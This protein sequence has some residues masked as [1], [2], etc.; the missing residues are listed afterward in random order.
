MRKTLAGCENITLPIMPATAQALHQQ[1]ASDHSNNQVLQRILMR[2]PAA[3]IA[4]YRRIEKSRPGASDIITGPA[5]ALSMLGFQAFTD[6]LNDLPQSTGPTENNL[7]QAGFAYSQA[8][9]AG[10]FARQLGAAI[11]LGNLEEIAVAALLQN[12]AI[13]ALW[14]VDSES[15]ARA[16]NAVRDGV[17]FE[18]AFSAELGEPLAQA[19]RRLAQ[20]WHFPSLA[21]EVMGNWDPL[22]KRPQ[23]VAFAN[24]LA[25]TTFAAWNQ[26]SLDL[27]TEMLHEFLGMPHDIVQARWRQSAA[28]AARE[29]NIPGYPLPAF[30]LVRLPGGE[31]E[32]EIPPL[33][34]RQA[35][36][37]K[38]QPKGLQQ[39]IAELMRQAQK[40]TGSKRAVFG[41]LNTD[42]SE[43][44]A[45]LALGG[46]KQDPMRCFKVGMTGRNLFSVLMQK[47]QSVWL[48][49]GNR[50]K[51]TPLLKPLPLDAAS[52]GGFFAMSVFAQDKPLGLLYV[53]GGR[54]DAEGYKRFRRL[55][56][57]FGHTLASHTQAAA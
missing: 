32:V 12:P 38:A 6:L 3:T 39:L 22:K 44:Q 15:A 2:D 25:Q 10:W 26:E 18:N 43:L 11:A 13:L 54:L 9:H 4:L 5:H 8:A 48:N 56:A 34:K 41:M 29:F 53:D 46:N 7:L 23:L 57:D 50:A 21:S 27:Q 14:Q 42:R 37:G 52:T 47:Q 40:E 55:C 31:E 36:D 20:A 45:R 33:P 16:T 1:L 19:N 17:S 35:T 28:E 49:T 30:D 24:M 51:Y